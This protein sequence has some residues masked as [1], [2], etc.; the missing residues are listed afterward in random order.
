LANVSF[1]RTEQVLE[2]QSGTRGF[3]ARLDIRRPGL[4]QE[5][6]PGS[7][8][9]LTGVYAGQ[10]GDPASGRDLD[11][12]ELLLNS[13]A[14]IRILERPSWWSLRH[15]LT[16]V[17]GMALV[18]LAAMVWISLLRRQVEERSRQ[19][20]VAIRRQEQ[21]E[22]Q[23]A[24]EEERARVARDL[25]DDLGAALTEIGLLG[26]LA[27][28][29]NTAPDRVRDHLTHI[30]DRAREMV[31]TLDEIVWSLNPKHDSLA[32][33]S[34]YFCE[35]AQQFLQLTPIRCRLEVAQNLP[36]RPLSSDQRHH[37]LLAFKEALTNVV[38]HARA[39]EVRIGIGVENESLAI[40]VADDGCGWDSA[41]RPAGG[42]GVRNLSRRIEQL[43]GSCQVLSQLG[44]GTRV[45]MILPLMNPTALGSGEL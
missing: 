21:A 30:T 32:S 33:L 23:R 8:L 9:E 7:R 40:T 18:L 11:A 20:T 1:N 3:V 44:H 17:G 16:V 4:R 29:T 41:S 5:L 45:R 13:P 39:T 31:T 12:F 24:L 22:G 6:L 2:L 19:L 28:R 38:R 34:R 36:D 42:D 26:G 27:Q 15:T 14:D 25:H 10:G 43:G 37:L 35:Y